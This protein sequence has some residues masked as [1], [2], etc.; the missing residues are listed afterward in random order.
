MPSRHE[1]DKESLDQAEGNRGEAL[2]V[3]PSLFEFTHLIRFIRI[4]ES[5]S[6]PWCSR[7]RQGPKCNARRHA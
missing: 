2:A 3:F 7:D 5:G 1:H 4:R 6:F